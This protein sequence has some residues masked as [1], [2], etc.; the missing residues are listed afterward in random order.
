MSIERLTP[1]ST[2][3]GE[4]DINMIRRLHHFF[5][6]VFHTLNLGAVCWDGD[7]FCAR[8]EVGEGI[9]LQQIRNLFLWR[10]GGR[11]R[12]GSMSLSPDQ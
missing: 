5:H 1:G 6:Q 2:G 11:E 10:E 4:Q 12:A 8:G 7:G 9:K 3:I